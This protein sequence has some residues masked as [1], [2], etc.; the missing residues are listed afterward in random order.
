M[1]ICSTI[2]KIPTFLLG[3]DAGG[4]GGGGAPSPEMAKLQAIVGEL[5][6]KV[7]A[8]NEKVDGGGGP[9]GGP[10]APGAKA[11]PLGTEMSKMGSAIEKLAGEIAAMKEEAKAKEPGDVPGFKV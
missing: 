11:G 5:A 3:G 1:I 7:D 9:M 4:G 8:V 6:D 10:L 2:S